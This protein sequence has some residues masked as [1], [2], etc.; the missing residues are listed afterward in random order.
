VNQTASDPENGTNRI[1]L[2]SLRSLSTNAVE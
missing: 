1:V 2:I